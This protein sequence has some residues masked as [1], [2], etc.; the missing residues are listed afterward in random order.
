M[1]DLIKV[2]ILDFFV[3]VQKLVLSNNVEGLAVVPIGLVLL[4]IVLKI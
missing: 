1:H 4:V 3:C 2:Q